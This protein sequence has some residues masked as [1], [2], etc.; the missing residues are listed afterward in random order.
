MTSPWPNLFPYPDMPLFVDD[1]GGFEKWTNENI[2]GNE[3]IRK[4]KKKKKKGP[5]LT[6]KKR[7]KKGPAITP[8][9]KKKKGPA[10]TAKK[11][12][13]KNK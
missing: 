2:V 3:R 7:K 8:K 5:A 6:P 1:P 13:K 11:K 9:K 10:I 4:H 12:K